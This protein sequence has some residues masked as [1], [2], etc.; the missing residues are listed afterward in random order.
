MNK[1]EKSPFPDTNISLRKIA[2]AAGKF[3]KL[4]GH[5]VLQALEDCKEGSIRIWI[6]DGGLNNIV[7]KSDEIPC[8]KAYKFIIDACESYQPDSKRF[9]MPE[10][11]AKPTVFKA[12]ERTELF[13]VPHLSRETYQA[14]IEDLSDD[15]LVDLLQLLKSEYDYM[16][17]SGGAFLPDEMMRAQ[18][19]AARRY[20]KV[21]QNHG[22]FDIKPKRNLKVLLKRYR[23]WVLQSV[24]KEYRAGA[25][26][27]P[28][29]YGVLLVD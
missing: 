17:T 3:Y 14:L 1:N 29:K 10:L 20:I 28:E 18:M 19:E 16:L 8:W 7:F 13:K 11:A 27:F 23:T 9:L 22:G 5:Q 15:I 6:A 25:K 2:K 24:N 4:T 12:P 21:Y 26:V